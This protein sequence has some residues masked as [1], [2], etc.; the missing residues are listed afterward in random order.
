MEGILKKRVFGHVMP[1]GQLKFESYAFFSFCVALR[2]FDSKASDPQPKKFVCRREYTNLILDPVRG[3]KP[4]TDI[5]QDFCNLVAAC[6]S[7]TYAGGKAFD[8][9]ESCAAPA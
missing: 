1:F 6:R 9:L 2:I 3:K 4:K 5:N 7:Y 8:A